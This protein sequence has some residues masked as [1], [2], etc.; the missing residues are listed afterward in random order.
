MFK[1]KIKKWNQRKIH[2]IIRL[3]WNKCAIFIIS[4]RS[5][6]CEKSDCSRISSFI[7]SVISKLSKFDKRRHLLMSKGIRREIISLK[8]DHQNDFGGI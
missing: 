1:Y 7:I 4:L 2:G 6:I 3:D 8:F 5:K